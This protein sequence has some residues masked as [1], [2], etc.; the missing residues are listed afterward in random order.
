MNGLVVR[1]AAGIL[2]TRPFKETPKVFQG[3]PAIDLHEGSLDDVLELEGIDGTRAAQGEKV[4]PRVGGEPAP[5]VGSHDS[6]CHRNG[7]SIIHSLV[8]YET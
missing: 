2:E 8:T 3:D 5:L 4:A 1:R 7:Q 6:K